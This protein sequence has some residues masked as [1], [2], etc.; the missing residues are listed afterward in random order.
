M[1]AI[2]IPLKSAQRHVMLQGKKRIIQNLHQLRQLEPGSILSH[3]ENDTSPK[4]L[5]K[6]WASILGCITKGRLNL[7]VE[8]IASGV[9]LMWRGLGC[10]INIG[11]GY[12]ADK[13]RQIYSQLPYQHVKVVWKK[14]RKFW[15]S[16]W[17]SVADF[18]RKTSLKVTHCPNRQGGLY[19]IQ[20]SKQRSWVKR[21]LSC[22]S[23]SGLDTV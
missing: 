23:V 7:I 22:Y 5:I 4:L 13:S 2:T 20:Q 21:W 8:S 9:D 19:F 14:I 3:R 15:L 18:R 16:P 12:A 17:Q 6:L 1:Q 10:R 11:P